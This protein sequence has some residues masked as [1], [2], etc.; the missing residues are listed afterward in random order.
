MYCRRGPNKYTRNWEDEDA[1]SKQQAAAPSTRGGRR[2]GRRGGANQTR[3][4]NVDQEDFPPLI[5]NNNENNG[6]APEPSLPNQG[7][8]YSNRTI[9]GKKQREDRNN[10][11]KPQRDAFPPL[12]TSAPQT[13]IGNHESTNRYVFC[14]QN[15]KYA[16]HKLQLMHY[17]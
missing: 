17:T 8:S 5:N 2:G 1:Y 7:L 3:N 10:V 16:S 11:K 14:V 12:D 13:N 15:K 4:V 6:N 9:S